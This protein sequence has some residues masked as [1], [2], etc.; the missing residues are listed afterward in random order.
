MD[1]ILLKDMVFYGYHGSGSAEK[2]L[3]QHWA[4]DVE[5]IGDLSTPARTDSLKDTIDYTKVYKQVKTVVENENFSL[6]E[7]LAQRIADKLLESFP[8][9]EVIVRVKKQH[10]P[11]G[12]P[13]SYASVEIR[14]KK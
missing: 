2:E 4:V 7:S 3:G 6:L 13:I 11:L 9:Y 12:G 1:K 10:P 14:R 5:I 8:A